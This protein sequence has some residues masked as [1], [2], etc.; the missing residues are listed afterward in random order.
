M[1]T[2]FRTVSAVALSAAMAAL[3]VPASAANLIV[4][5]QFNTPNVGATWNLFTNGGVPGWTSNNN[6]TEID[7][8]PG[9]VGMPCFDAGCQN[10]ELDGTTFDTISQ[11][12]SGLTPGMKYLLTWAYGDRPGSGPQEANVFFGGALVTQDSNAGMT[13]SMW[14]VN[15]VM[16]TATATTEVLSF[17]A[18]DTSGIGGDPGIGN[19]IADVSL[20]PEPAS[21]AL[22][23]AGLAGLGLIRRRRAR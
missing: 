12:V 5:G 23:G 22:L 17:A 16:V 8:S 18:V 3:A 1:K 13:P 14:M 6:E 4:N 9:A 11:T 7:N 19:E 20:V 2:L 15:S 10:L 21:L